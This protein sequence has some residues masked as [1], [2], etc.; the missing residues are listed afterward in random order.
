MGK[1]DEFGTIEPNKRADLLLVD[2]DP[3]ADIRNTSRISAVVLNG[4]L[5]DRR[6]LDRLL[7]TA[8]AEV[9]TVT[10]PTPPALTLAIKST[11]ESAFAGMWE[12]E[13]PD[14][15][16]RIAMQLSVQ[17]PQ[18]T[19]TLRAG[20]QTVQIFEGD[21][22]G[23]TIAF[24]FNSPDAHREIALTG[25][26]KGDEM[27][28]T[29]E[30]RVRQGGLPGGQGLFGVGGPPRFTSLDARSPGTRSRGRPGGTEEVIYRFAGRLHG[31][32]AG[33]L[34]RLAG[35]RQLVL[36]RPERAWRALRFGGEHAS[37]D[38]PTVRCLD[39]VE[40]IDAAVAVLAVD[41]EVVGRPHRRDGSVDAHF[42]VPDALAHGLLRLLQ[43]R[44]VL[45]VRERSR[46]APR[47]TC[48]HRVE[49]A[50]RH[51]DLPRTFN[52]TRGHR[53]EEHLHR[54]QYGVAV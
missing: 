38:L 27:T 32:E 14:L 51:E 24:K 43:L 50:L 36:E 28:F 39:E 48:V 15:G 21:V 23:N 11:G 6:A 47:F 33:P 1:L 13:V 34:G 29:R 35:E 45:L 22:S 12:A 42:G 19:G 52:I 4:R 40:R 18:V 10:L 30:V 7:A 16:Q 37:G 26:L 9:R 2:A 41:P 53:V 31:T 5:L 25:V 46:F 20:G 49:A 8:E 44:Q 54:L 3:L 17:G